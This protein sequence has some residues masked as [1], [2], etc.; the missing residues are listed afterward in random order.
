MEEIV[1]SVTSWVRSSSFTKKTK[2]FVSNDEFPS[3]VSVFTSSMHFSYTIN[4][5]EFE[6]AITIRKQCDECEI[7][8]Q[9]DELD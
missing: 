6:L 8:K 4:F 9:C 7:R 2:G 1:A 5:R 3:C